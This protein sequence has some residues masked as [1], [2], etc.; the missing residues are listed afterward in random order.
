M[1][2]RA[3]RASSRARLPG[4]QASRSWPPAARPWS[5]PEK[6]LTRRRRRDPR[7]GDAAAPSIVFLANPNNPTGTYLPLRGGEAPARRACRRRASRARRGL[8]RICPPQRLRGRAR[9]RRAPA[10]NV[11]MTRTFSKIYGLATLRLGWMVGAGR[12]SIDAREPHPRALQRQRA[13]DR[14]RHRGAR[15]RGAC[16][17]RPSPTTRRWLPWLTREIEALGLDGDAE[18]RQL[19]PDPFP[20]RRRADARKDADAF[21]TRRGLDAARASAPTAC[22]T[23]CA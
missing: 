8:C 2:A 3:T 14:R 5:P 12:M 23:A 21:L 15:R 11:V 13:G 19:P 16:R 20:E 18:R 22:R 1:S 17:R 7:Q 10:E 4:L 6:D 9:A